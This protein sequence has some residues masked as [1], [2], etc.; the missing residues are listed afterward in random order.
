MKEPPGGVRLDTGGF[1][2]TGATTNQS[3]THQQNSVRE[4]SQRP[5]APPMLAGLADPANMG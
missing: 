2:E 4:K 5:H 1:S 3:A